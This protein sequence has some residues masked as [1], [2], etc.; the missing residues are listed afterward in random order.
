MYLLETDEI[1]D[2]YSLPNPVYNESLIYGDWNLNSVVSLKVHA[3][4]RIQNNGS[5]FAH[6]FLC[7]QTHIVIDP[8]ASNYDPHSVIHKSTLLTR[9]M[10]ERKVV[11]KRNLIGGQVED[12]DEPQGDPSKSTA[13]DSETSA[14]I[15]KDTAWVSY[16][17]P[18][19]TIALVTENAA[20]PRNLPPAISKR[21]IGTLLFV[22]VLTK[23]Y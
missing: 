23:R 14:D 5:L 9:F 21:T 3:D 2:F 13:N 7:T 22:Y 16:W 15:T 10:P 1:S 17:F 11:K 4:V 18:N 8:A 20:L 12:E 6:L 19:M